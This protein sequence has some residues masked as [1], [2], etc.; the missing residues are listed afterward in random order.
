MSL[1]LLTTLLA[2][3]LLAWIAAR[4]AA[5]MGWMRGA[6]LGLALGLFGHFAID[7]SYVIWYDFPI[8]Y[9]LAQLAVQAVGWALGGAAAGWWVGR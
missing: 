6:G 3:F 7:A 8:E 4:L 2:G 9:G 5:P 1:E